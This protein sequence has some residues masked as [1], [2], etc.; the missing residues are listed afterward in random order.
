MEWWNYGF[1]G[2]LSI[3]NG[4]FNFI[5]QYS[6]IPLFQMAGILIYPLIITQSQYVVEIPRR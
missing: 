5:T 2:I 6:N 3:K 4:L 1:E